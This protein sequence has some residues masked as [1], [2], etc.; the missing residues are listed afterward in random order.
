MAN[1]KEVRVRIGSVNTTMQITKAMKL[2]SAS[3]LK[4]AQDRITQMRPYSEKLN[5]ILGNVMEALKGGEISLPLNQKR[6][7]KNVLIVLM[8]ADKGLCGGFNA[9]LYKTTL[10][11]LNETYTQQLQTGNLTIMTIGKKGYDAFKKA[12]KVNFNTDH[13]GLFSALNFDKSQVVSKAITDEF[14]SGKYDVVELVYAKFINAA[15]QDFTVERF[16]PVEQSAQTVKQAINS[17]YIFQPEKQVL[18]QELGPKILNTQFFKA[19]LDTNASEH[20]ARMVAMESATN[21]A[22]ELLR[23]LK[24]QYN[25]ERQAAITKEILEIVGGAAAL[26]EK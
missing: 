26:E 22:N 20:G 10:R 12:P 4:R 25:R 15:S 2:V 3:K 14:L 24:I 16:L 11:L 1:L 17:D 13:I 23:S 9:N 21:N 8:T 6:E 18:L 19:L 5:Y 7:P